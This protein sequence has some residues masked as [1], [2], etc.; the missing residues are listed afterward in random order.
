VRD[1][2]RRRRGRLAHARCCSCS[3]WPPPTDG[4]ARRPAIGASP[5]VGIH[6]LVV[7]VAFALLLAVLWR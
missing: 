7:D 4:A 5:R 6:Q 1:R 3:R 2:R